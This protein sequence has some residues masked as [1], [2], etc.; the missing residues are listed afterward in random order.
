[1]QCLRLTAPKAAGYQGL[2][3]RAASR[4]VSRIPP[5]SQLSR[6][7]PAGTSAA[8]A[9]TASVHSRRSAAISAVKRRNAAIISCVSFS[10]VNP[11]Y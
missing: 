11:V 6:R 7:H 2:C 4:T 8:S 10:M 9:S 1:M 3:A 5:A